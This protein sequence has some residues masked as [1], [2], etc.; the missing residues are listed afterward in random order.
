M[1]Y[2]SIRYARSRRACPAVRHGNVTKSIIVFKNPIILTREESYELSD[3]FHT[4]RLSDEDYLKFRDN[5][6]RT[7]QLL[8]NAKALTDYMISLGHDGLISVGRG[9]LEIVDYRPYL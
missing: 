5:E 1:K 2:V 7:E 4:V 9:E 3:K 6:E 8:K